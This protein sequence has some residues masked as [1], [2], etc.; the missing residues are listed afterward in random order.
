MRCF[1]NQVSLS[2][3]SSVLCHIWEGIQ[4]DPPGYNKARLILQIY[5]SIAYDYDILG[6]SSD[7][8]RDTAISESF[9]YYSS[10]PHYCNNVI[11]S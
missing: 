7:Q 6:P 10:V 2:I 5:N 11:N 9:S 4:K 3:K 1:R 8:L